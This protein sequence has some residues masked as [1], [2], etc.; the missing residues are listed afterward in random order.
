MKYHIL[1]KFYGSAAKKKERQSTDGAKGNVDGGLRMGPGEWKYVFI[2]CQLFDSMWQIN[3]FMM[4]VSHVGDTLSSDRL[5]Q[6]MSW[7]LTTFVKPTP[8]PRSLR[9]THC[10]P[11]FLNAPNGQHRVDLL[12]GSFQNVLKWPLRSDTNEF[13]FYRNLCDFLRRSNRKA[14]PDL[15][16]QS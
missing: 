7:Q 11:S 10:L 16:K 12:W 9:E 1:H 15:E 5:P 13:I 8:I 3:K 6:W 2:D 14:V 4:S